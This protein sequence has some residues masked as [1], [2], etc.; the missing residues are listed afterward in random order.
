MF[1]PV[2]SESYLSSKRVSWSAWCSGCTSL[3][4]LV[5]SEHEVI[6]YIA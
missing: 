4:S 6:I 3:R 1:W 5:Y 2:I